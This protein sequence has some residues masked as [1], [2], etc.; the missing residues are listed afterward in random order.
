MKEF[1][2]IYNQHK[3][4]IEDFLIETTKN[5]GL[6]NLPK[7]DERIKKLFKVFPSLELVYFIDNTTYTQTSSNFYKEDEDKKHFGKDRAYLISKVKFE[8][9]DI[10]ISAPYVSS[11]T[12]SS[13]I[14]LL[15]KLDNNEIMLL[16]FE[17]VKL[18]ERLGLVEINF[19]FNTV[20]KLFYT[21][22]G[23]TMIA[24]S[25][26]IIGYA[27]FEFLYSFL[28]KFDFSIDTIFKPIIALTLGLA[29]FDLAKTVLEQ[30]VF[31]KSYAKNH[32]L[33]IQVFTKFL[34]TIIIALS[35]EALM[36]VFKIAIENYDQMINAFYLL[37]GIS[38][39]VIS[40]G[41]FIF[42]SRKKAN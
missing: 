4:E 17:L 30:E 14:T 19:E 3:Q 7:T 8:G 24:L 5:S 1:I 26:F 35:I 41:I 36:V 42:L 18:L 2:E 33:E 11:A 22:T 27:S 23:F 13:C 21:I 40:L 9:R 28:L 6:I 38:L 20:T 34:I 15:Y 37:G 12:G 16:D 25:F 31:F 29:I 32:K 39:I 10:A